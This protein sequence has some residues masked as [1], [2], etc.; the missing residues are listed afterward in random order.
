MTD[1]ILQSQKDDDDVV[2]AMQSQQVLKTSV[3]V[4]YS[5][6]QR[7]TDLLSR[8]YPNSELWAED[9]LNEANHIFSLGIEQA[10]KELECPILY[11]ERK[12]RK[13]VMINLGKIANEFLKSS[14]YPEMRAVTL[15]QTINKVLGL[16]DDRTK[17]KYERCIHQY[18]GRPGELGL[19]DVSGFVERLPK[20]FVDTTSSTSS[21]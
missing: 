4:S 16:G 11:E 9:K 6:Y 3:D 14:A 8:K 10:E 18:I 5:T 15:R 21:F 13:D 12:P 17:K 1:T 2:V 19:T 20:Q 7:F